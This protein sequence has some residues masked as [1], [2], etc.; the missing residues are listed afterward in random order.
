[1]KLYIGMLFNEKGLFPPYDGIWRIV[2]IK[3]EYIYYVCIYNSLGQRVSTQPVFSA[4]IINLI[5][6]I[7]PL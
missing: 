1:M 2:G 6:Y 4:K 5:P 3:R 7:T